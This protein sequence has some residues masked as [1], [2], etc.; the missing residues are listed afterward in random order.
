MLRLVVRL[1]G[2]PDRGVNVTVVRYLVGV[3]QHA[4][5]GLADPAHDL[6]IG[7]GVGRKL[8]RLYD[9]SHFPLGSHRSQ[10][11]PEVF[12]LDF[13]AHVLLDVLAQ[14]LLVG[15]EQPALLPGPLAALQ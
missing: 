11:R 7:F 4:R 5:H 8:S 15:G 14:P 13:F 10:G 9:F 6:A 12:C 1:E 2:F 3:A